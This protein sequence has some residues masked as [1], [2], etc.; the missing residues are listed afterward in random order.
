MKTT[1]AITALL[2][3]SAATSAW[4][5]PPSCNNPNH[6]HSHRS[7]GFV[8]PD[9]PGY[10]WGFANGAADSYGWWD[11]GVL[12]P[13]GANRVGEYYFP[14]YMSVPP[15]QAFLPSY[16]NPIPTR[17]QRYVA[18]SGCGGAHPAGGPPLA[19]AMT[20]EHPYQDTIGSGPRVSL[21]AFSGRT[22]APPTQAG[23]SGLTP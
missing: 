10:G 7:N 3:L 1:T 12:L 14:R 6:R 2:A 18:F 13:L 11:H 17:G 8:L 5:G 16:Y 23:T 21:P 22:E 4:A 15:T 20:P 19:S 9:G